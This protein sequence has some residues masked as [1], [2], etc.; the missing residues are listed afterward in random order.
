MVC[1]EGVCF[2]NHGIRMEQGGLMKGFEREDQ[3][4]S[5]CGL[6]CGLCTMRLGGY[7]PGCGGGAGN[8]SC[9][10]ARCGLDHGGVEYCFQCGEFP[11]ARYQK[12]EEY[13]SFITHRGRLRDLERA[14]QSGVDA[15]Q[16]EQRER[17]ALLGVLLERYND[18][19]RKT[20]FS[21]AANL[22]EL[23]DLREILERLADEAAGL[24]L[25]ERAGHAAALC[26]EAS[27]RRGVDLRLRKPPGKSGK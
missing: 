24:P 26:K 13:D 20:L 7:C 16:A 23:E 11:C 27:A 4:F 1:A 19:R 2:E 9:A 10:I 6:N 25:K 5:L 22:L 18:G 3:L 17:C 8:Q 14:R 12:E 21:L 15:Y